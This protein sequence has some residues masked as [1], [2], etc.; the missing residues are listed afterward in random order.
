MPTRRSP[1]KRRLVTPGRVILGLFL[2][3]VALGLL[4]IP[5]LKAPGHAQ[6]AKA[7][8]EAARTS[9]STGDFASA[10]ASVQS[11]RRHADQ[12]Q[13]AMQ[14]IGGDVW[15]LVPVLGRPISDVRHLGNALDDLTS[16]AEIAVDTWPQVNGDQATLLEDGQVDLATLERLT[17]QVGTASDKL[18]TAESEL[19]EVAD[20]R[21]VSGPLLAEARDE[22]LGLVSPLAD[23][24]DALSPVLDTLPGMLGSENERK[25]L[26]AM[27]NPSEQ[28]YSGGAVLALS[29]LT[30]EDGRFDVSE[31]F[32][33]SESPAFFRPYYWLK[34]KGNPFHRGRQSAQTATYAPSWPVSGNELLNA[35]RSLRGRPGA[36]V[37]AVDTV[38]LGRLLEFTGPLT[39]PGYPPLTPDNFVYETVGNYD[40]HP[41]PLERRALNKAL[42]P[43]FTEALLA[44]DDVVDKMTAIH[45]LAQARHFAVYFRNPEP[46]AAFARL[47]LVG[48]L[49]DTE[50]DY[51]GV[52]NQN[53]NV[54]KADYW[55][56]RV[57]ESEVDLR[58]DGSARVRL[59]INVHNDSPPPAPG[60][61]YQVGQSYTTR[62]N[63]MSL[64]AFLPMG[65]T[66]DSTRLDGKVVQFTP[67]Q[68]F[69][70][71][72]VR[73]TID[74]P[75]QSRKTYEITYDV[76]SAATVDEDG[77]LTYRLD[78]TPQ[79]MV[80]PQAVSVRVR[81]PRGV[82]V[83]A[84]PDGWQGNGG[85][86]ATYENP[87]LVTQPSF[88]VT[89]TPA[90]DAT[91]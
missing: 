37:I 66:I 50:H 57:V 54:S 48:D 43:A 25:Y 60:A 59:R 91:P 81:F 9:F 21:M 51:I 78:L 72:F 71:P 49:P 75:P 15:S 70:R 5:F 27:L 18:A 7:D 2:L 88:T 14:G 45:E 44:P 24:I 61:Y 6:G 11:A 38:A 86:V 68:Y 4:A 82:E 56:R 83:G 79:G 12:V 69:G 17:N 33:A 39:V 76:P 26:I 36:G 41:D 8:L 73:R 64:A 34:V 47:G 20:T 80:T 52:F 63:G 31:A 55:Q 40:A 65:A 3:V 19:T 10:E 89:G 42:A 1:A 90:P 28:R 87:G 30:T 67:R 53:T 32:D 29:V 58:P 84:L 13:G 85:R 77:R 22:A 62:W 35:F 74:F 23:G 16:V 46:Q